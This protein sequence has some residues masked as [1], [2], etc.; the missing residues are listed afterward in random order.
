MSAALRSLLQKTDCYP[1]SLRISR[2]PLITKFKTQQK[3][4]ANSTNSPQD[5]PQDDACGNA[6]SHRLPLPP[7][8]SAMSTSPPPSPPSHPLRQVTVD[9]ELK[10]PSLFMRISGH[11]NPNLAI[12]FPPFSITPL[13]IRDLLKHRQRNHRLISL[14][15]ALLQPDLQ[16]LG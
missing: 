9:P 12:C 2:P 3:A 7:A 14:D 4:P 6:S 13:P 16:L 1:L 11:I 15:L 8:Q 10:D 5:N